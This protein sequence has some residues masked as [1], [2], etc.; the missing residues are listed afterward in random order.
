MKICPKILVIAMC[1]AF[2]ATPS[3]AR[4]QYTDDNAPRQAAKKQPDKYS[5]EGIKYCLESHG[6]EEGTDFKKDEARGKVIY[7]K[8][9]LREPTFANRLDEIWQ[10]AKP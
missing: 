4:G 6:L 8:A 9:S 5:Y 2:F 10:C 1:A 7:N 3:L